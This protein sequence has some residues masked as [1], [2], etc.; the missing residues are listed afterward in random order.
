MLVSWLIA[1]IRL[2]Q[3]CISPVISRW[4]QCRYYPTCSEYAVLAIR[5]YGLRRGVRKT[6]QR[7]RRCSPYS[8]DSCLDLP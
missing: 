2:Y 4:I 8:L 5:K 1:C 7:L 6:W 3:R